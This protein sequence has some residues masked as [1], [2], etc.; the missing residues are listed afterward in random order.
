MNEMQ[1]F[2]QKIID[3]FRSNDGIVGGPFEGAPLLLLGT[4]GAKSGAARVNPLAYLEDGERL[5]IF[6]SFAGADVHP[7]WYF[8]LRV[9]PEVTVEVGNEKFAARAETVEEPERSGLYKKM[10]GLMPAFAEYESKTDRVIPVISL[11]RS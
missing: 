4:T 9:N 1:A 8:N 3:E 6:A 11:T 5:V 10:A 7:P 2:N